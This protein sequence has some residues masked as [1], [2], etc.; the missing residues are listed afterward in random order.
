MKKRKSGEQEIVK[1]DELVNWLKEK[2][3]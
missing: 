2:G 3:C 1:I